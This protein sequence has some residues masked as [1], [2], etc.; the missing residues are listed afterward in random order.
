MGLNSEFK[1][2]EE[3]QTTHFDLTENM[4]EC[5]KKIWIYRKEPESDYQNSTFT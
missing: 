4:N 2:K 3:L 1:K 5:E